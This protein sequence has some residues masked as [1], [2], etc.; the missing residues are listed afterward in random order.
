M[1]TIRYKVYPKQMNIKKSR[2]IASP[3]AR[4]NSRHLATVPLVSPLNDV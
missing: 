2:K 1:R 3:L 4:E